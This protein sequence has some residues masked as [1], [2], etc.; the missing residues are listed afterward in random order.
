MP[1]QV[2][3]LPNP[4]TLLQTAHTLACGGLRISNWFKSILCVFLKIKVCPVNTYDWY[5]S[6]TSLVADG[7]KDQS[8]SAAATVRVQYMSVGEL[9]SCG[10]G[11][12]EYIQGAPKTN[13]C[14]VEM[15]CMAA[16]P[17]DNADNRYECEQSMFTN[18]QRIPQAA[19]AER[20]NRSA[21]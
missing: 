12:P 13:V 19:T 7:Q 1:S 14:V 10:I 16:D 6:R 20:A 5:I 18:A 11:L 3:L 17:T 4:N 21:L 2:G 15:A 9:Q 8:L